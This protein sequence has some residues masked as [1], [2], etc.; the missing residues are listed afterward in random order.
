MFDEL[1]GASNIKSKPN[2]L[3]VIAALKHIQQHLK[4][5]KQIPSNG[6]ALFVNK[7]TIKTLTPPLPITQFVYRCD[8]KYHVDTLLSLYDT[9]DTEGIVLVSGSVC[10]IYTYTN[11]PTLICKMDVSLQSRQK[12]GGQSA[13]RIARLAEEKRQLY[14]QQIVEKIN[15]V[16]LNAEKSHVIIKH[17][18]IAG[19]AEMKKQVGTSDNIDYRLKPILLPLVTIDTIDDD[20]IHAIVAMQ[21]FHT[22]QLCQDDMLCRMV[23]QQ[24]NI[25]ALI[26][27][28][29]EIDYYIK[30][31]NCQQ[32]YVHASVVNNYT[33]VDMVIINTTGAY[34]MMF[35]KYG[36]VALQP[37]Y[38]ME[39]IDD[40]R[41]DEI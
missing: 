6:V 8:K 1:S 31:F 27:G 2:K 32:L 36:G 23:V 35:C 26:Y 10:L 19:P 21:L 34:G 41:V 17:L 5:Y 13:L 11:T 25:G 16:Y 40:C 12:K 33:N 14:C 22:K 29:Q 24:I 39:Y 38:M 20:T 9:H 4:L 37:Y 3:A 15:T 28:Q 18:L 30:H 7:D